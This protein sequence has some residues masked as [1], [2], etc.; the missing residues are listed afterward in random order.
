MQIQ[1]QKHELTREE[2]EEYQRELMLA[3][4]RIRRQIFESRSRRGFGEGMKFGI[5]AA[6]IFVITFVGMNFGAYSKQAN[7]WLANIRASEIT[8]V[9]VNQPTA[10]PDKIEIK[11]TI[12]KIE[13]KNELPPLLAE[14]SPPDNRLI[15]P[16]LKIHA[17]IR[18]AENANL[19]LASWDEI[20]E[21]VQDALRFGV[22]NFPGTAKPGERGNAFIT[23]HSSYYPLLTGRYKDIFA[24]LPQIEIG[25]EIEVWQDQ[26]K[27]IYHVSEKYEVSPAETDVLNDSNDSRLT[28]MTCTPLG[29]AIKRLIVTAQLEESA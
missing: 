22:V 17:P 7:F 12:P 2:E 25:E 29:T 10:K 15:I 11:K 28:L 24:L 26:R 4:A 16:R 21:Q 23:G 9:E 19:N 14:I 27:F 5:T 6:V 20:E 8:K 18:T 3:E 13:K 1:I